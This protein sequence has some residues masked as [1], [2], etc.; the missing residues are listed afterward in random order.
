MLGSER[1]NERKKMIYLLGR[2]VWRVCVWVLVKLGGKK[3]MEVGEGVG[4]K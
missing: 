1:V 3:K 4:V 2:I